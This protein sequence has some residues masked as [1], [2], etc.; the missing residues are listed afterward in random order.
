MAQ[1]ILLQDRFYPIRSSLPSCIRLPKAN[2]NNFKLKSQFINTL[3]TY[4][5]LESEGSYLF[6]REFKEV[7]VM[8]KMQ[9]LGDDVVRLRFVPFSF[10][11]L[12]KKWL[13]S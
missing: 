13:Y 7:C 4:H 2:G 11:D 1:T 6:I 12:T 3:P 5:E 10:K 9:Q 8:M